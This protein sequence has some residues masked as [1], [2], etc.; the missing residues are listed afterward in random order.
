MTIVSPLW[1]G[2]CALPTRTRPTTCAH[3][4]SGICDLLSKFAQGGLNHREVGSPRHNHHLAVLLD[5]RFQQ[6]AFHQRGL[7]A[8]SG[9]QAR[10]HLD[11]WW[12]VAVKVAVKLQAALAADH[13]PIL[14]LRVLVQEV[15]RGGQVIQAAGATGNQVGGRTHTLR[16]IANFNAFQFQ[17]DWRQVGIA[18]HLAGQSVQLWWLWRS[19]LHHPNKQRARMV[20]KID[21]V[22]E[23]LHNERA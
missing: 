20:N 19:Y 4:R 10:T 17:P 9:D 22:V 1:R 6:A 11:T 15:Y 7:G 2:G 14:T 5:M 21:V 8:L 12:L 3:A 13:R 18:Q 23:A 16:E